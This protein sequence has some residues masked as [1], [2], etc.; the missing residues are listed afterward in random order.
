M[1]MLKL[2]TQSEYSDNRDPKLPGE[3]IRR[4]A[5]IESC[6]HK[7]WKRITFR[8]LRSTSEQNKLVRGISSTRLREAIRSMQ[9]EELK[10]AL[11]SMALSPG[12]LLEL[13]SDSSQQREEE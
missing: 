4:H 2:L 10:T 12:L 11:K 1:S 7:R 13:V 8:F 6:R 5:H 3:V 9:G